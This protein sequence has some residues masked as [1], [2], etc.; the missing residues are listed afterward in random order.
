MLHI[1]VYE[2]ARYVWSRS[3]LA[4]LDR[5][6]VTIHSPSEQRLDLVPNR[7]VLHFTF[8]HKEL[9]FGGYFPSDQDYQVWLE[10]EKTL[11]YANTLF[12]KNS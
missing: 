3:S 9:L 11:V 8:R 7:D 2:R 12:P 1:A 6:G 10:E 5:R 4:P